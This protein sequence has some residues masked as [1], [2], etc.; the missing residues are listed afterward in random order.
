MAHIHTYIHIYICTYIRTLHTLCAHV[1]IHTTYTH[2]NMQND[3]YT[4]IHITFIHTTYIN[5]RSWT[6]KGLLHG[7]KLYYYDTYYIHTY[8][9][10]Y[11][12]LGL[13]IYAYIHTYHGK[14][15]QD[16]DEPLYVLIL[17]LLAGRWVLSR[18]AEDQS[19]YNWQLVVCINVAFYLIFQS[20]VHLRILYLK[21]QSKCTY[22]HTYTYTYTYTYIQFLLT[23]VDVESF[24]ILTM[25]AY[26]AA[27]AI[28][29]AFSPRYIHMIIYIHTYL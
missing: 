18:E 26:P 3:L 10:K 2:T 22:I 4:F 23:L 5:L 9:H 29:T 24:I 11:T 8:I 28:S 17:A 12:F 1:Y 27:S 6:Q 7:W 13:W 16:D 15:D 19:A 20:T 21:N 25:C 14:R